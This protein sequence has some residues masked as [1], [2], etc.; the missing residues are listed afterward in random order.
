LSDNDYNAHWERKFREG[1]WGKYPPEDLVRFVG[2]NFPGDSRIDKKALEIGC[3]PGAN[4]WFLYREGFHVSGIDSS[5]TAIE[6]ARARIIREDVNQTRHNSEKPDLRVGNFISLPWKDDSFDLV[7][8]IFALYANR[9]DI[10][11]KAVDEVFRVLKPGGKFYSKL[12]GRKTIGYGSGDMIEVG[13]YSNITTGPCMEMGV[14]HFFDIEEI[15]TLFAMFNIS[16]VDQ[17]TRTDRLR[18][19]DSIEEFHCQ[20]LKPGNAES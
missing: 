6:K 14:A 13:T 4:L 15:N 1:E 2:R 9:L 3:G 20:F 11:R 18:S 7:I 8:D 19:F 12:W 17:L 10:M 16:I 5:S